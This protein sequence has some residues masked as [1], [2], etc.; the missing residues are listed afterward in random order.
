M[1]KQSVNEY[2]ISNTLISIEELCYV[3]VPWS[4]TDNNNDTGI[5]YYLISVPIGR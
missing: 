5:E 3:S 1:L 4:I 2:E